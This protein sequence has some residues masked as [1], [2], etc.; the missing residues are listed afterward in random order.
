MLECPLRTSWTSRRGEPHWGLNLPHIGGFIY[1]LYCSPRKK[2][3]ISYNFFLKFGKLSSFSLWMF[4]HNL[5]TSMYFILYLHLIEYWLNKWL[6]IIIWVRSSENTA[7]GNGWER[8]YFVSSLLNL[9]FVFFSLHPFP[10]TLIDITKT[11]RL[12]AVTGWVLFSHELGQKLHEGL[13]VELQ[14]LTVRRRSRQGINVNEENMYFFIFVYSQLP[15]SK[16]WQIMI[17]VSLMRRFYV[18][19]LGWMAD[20]SLRKWSS[21]KMS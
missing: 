21:D 16:C 4:E 8:G 17:E 9:G 7:Q 2:F 14:L 13:W 15:S 11:T 19:V 3:R 6:C 18:T 12:K 20:G 5:L 10:K 1:S